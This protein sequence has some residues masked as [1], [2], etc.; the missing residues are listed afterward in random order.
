MFTTILVANDGSD[1][2]RNA[3]RIAGNLAAKY[4]AELFVAHVVSDQA[5]PEQLRR[6][7]E[8]EHLVK[9]SEPEPNSTFGRLSLKPS[10]EVEEQQLRSAI[11]TKVLEQ[12]VALAKHEGAT[13]AKPLGLEG[14]AAEALVEAVGRH[15]ADL[16]VI[17]S[18]GFGPLGRLLHGS[19]STE[20][21]QQVRCPCLIVKRAD[22]S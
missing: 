1:H 16:V 12:G 14:D 20:V 15:G 21:S 17:G 6:M 5:V 4:D 7:A 10:P 3:T 11:S 18:R 13:K 22:N 2:G 8:V 19:V 9:E